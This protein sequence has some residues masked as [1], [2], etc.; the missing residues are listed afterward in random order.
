MPDLARG[1][2]HRQAGGKA[3]G[4]TSVVVWLTVRSGR[5]SSGCAS[6]AACT[7]TK[8]SLWSR[9]LSMRAGSWLGRISYVVGVP[10]DSTDGVRAA[11]TGHASLALLNAAAEASGLFS[12]RVSS[13]PGFSSPAGATQPAHPTRLRAPRS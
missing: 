8:V 10:R 11:R 5:G 12:W 7:S 2:S 1:T 13:S 4:G 6:A 3:R 9:A